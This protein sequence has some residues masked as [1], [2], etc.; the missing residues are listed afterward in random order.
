VK[1]LQRALASPGWLLAAVFIAFF[2]LLGDGAL[3]DIDEGAFSEATREMFERGDFAATWLNGEPRYDKPILIYWLQALSTYLLGFTEFA[4][5][6]P[7]A[8]AASLWAWAVWGFARRRLGAEA[9][10]AAALTLTFSLFVVIEGRAATADALLNL[11]IALTFFDMWRWME[12]P[13]RRILARVYLWLALGLLTKGP[14]AVA[15]P[16]LA[17]LVYMAGLGR[18]RLWWRALRDPWGWA[19]LL[20]IVL[21]WGVAVYRDQGWAFFEGFL[22]QHNLERF[23]DTLEGHGGHWWYYLLAAPLVVWPF[24]GWLV[25][26]ARALRADWADPLGR[27]L[28]SWFGVVLV[29]FSLSNTQLPHYLLYGATPLFLLMGRHREALRNRWVAFGPPLLL[30]VLLA[31]LPEILALAARHGHGEYPRAIFAYGA[32]SLGWGYRLPVLAALA[33]VLLLAVGHHLPTW[34]ALTISGFFTTLAL[35]GAFG[36]A[37]FRIYQ[38]PVKEAGLIAR[39]LGRPAVFFESRFP[40]FSVYRRAVTPKAVPGPGELALTRV[41]RLKD[42]PVRLGDR[43]YRVIY[44]RGGIALIQ[45]DE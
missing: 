12:R 23:A 1:A 20:L 37:F 22:L 41:D 29:L 21:P 4:L 25:P 30:L 8:L 11:F 18:L 15:L 31:A 7:S 36:P 28:W 34:R 19:L 6:L 42:L 24:S 38:G 3:Y 44:R 26:V 43:G 32:R 40:S 17:S 27:F 2:W 16:L 45:V 10:L 35:N 9:A 33:G 13:R 5:R 39:E 14:V